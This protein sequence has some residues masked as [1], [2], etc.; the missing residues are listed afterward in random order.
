MK[1]HLLILLLICSNL[2]LKADNRVEIYWTAGGM[3]VYHNNC[4]FTNYNKH[5]GYE[6]WNSYTSEGGN[7]EDY[8]TLSDYSTS[9][10]YWREEGDFENLKN[11]CIKDGHDCY[12]EKHD[13]DHASDGQLYCW[14]FVRMN[15]NEVKEIKRY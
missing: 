14:F 4:C 1:K 11:E 12:F 5:S 9:G 6:W 7:N 13:W 8:Y 10:L 15:K 2:I 3:T